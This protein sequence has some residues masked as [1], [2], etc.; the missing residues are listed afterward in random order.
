MKETPQSNCRRMIVK[1]GAERVVGHIAGDVPLQIT[2][3]MGNNGFGLYLD[4]PRARAAV[5][6]EWE[7]IH[8][9]QRAAHR[10]DRWLVL[11]PA[12]MVPRRVQDEVVGDGIERIA[13]L[14]RAGGSKWVVRLVYASVILTVV[15][16]IVRY[17][18]RA[19]KG[20]KARK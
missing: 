15:A 17:W 10:F 19:I 2:A 13:A 11:L 18:V 3:R 14:V 9:S 16:E 20:E 1:V 12:R 5:L 8:E 6:L 7:R 4:D